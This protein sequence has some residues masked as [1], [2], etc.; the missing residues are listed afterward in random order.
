M[1]KYELTTECKEFLGRKLYRIK[2][3]IN[4]S[5]IKKGDLGGWIEKE[6]NLSQEGNAWV[7]GDAT[8][9]DNAKVYGDAWVYGNARVF[10]NAE[11]KKKTHLLE[12]GFIGSRNDVTTFFRTKNK[13]IFVKCGCFNGNIDEFEK[14]VQKVH[15]DDK[16]GRVYALAIAMAREQIAPDDEDVEAEDE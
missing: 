2:A 7:Y 6:E 11:I 8:V 3:L 12:I 15:G 13:E 14:Q 9:Y 1:K 4:F 10:G 5:N 16:H